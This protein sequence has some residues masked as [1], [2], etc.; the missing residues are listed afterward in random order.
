MRAA[1]KCIERK[2]HKKKRKKNSEA[3]KYTDNGSKRYKFVEEL[4][5]LKHDNEIKQEEIEH[6]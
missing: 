3:F 5:R 4:A 1:K 6:L 2:K